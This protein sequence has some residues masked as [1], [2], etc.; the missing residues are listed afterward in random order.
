VRGATRRAGPESDAVRAGS[1]RSR[2]V[3]APAAGA[4]EA[5]DWSAGAASSGTAWRQQ[6]AEES[7]GASPSVQQ[8]VAAPDIRQD[9]AFPEGGG[10][11]R[12]DTDTSSAARAATAPR[13]RNGCPDELSIAR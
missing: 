3:T 11:A 10:S 12:A 9:G 4:K 13:K 6:P 1:G 8:H 7:R 2:V 5:F